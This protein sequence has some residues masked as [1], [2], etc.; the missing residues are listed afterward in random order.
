MLVTFSDI[1]KRI[2]KLGSKPSARL[3]NMRE[4]RL[5]TN[6]NTFCKENAINVIR[7]WESLDENTDTAYNKALDT[8]E[9][10][11]NNTNS[12]IIRSTCNILLEDV[13]KVRDPSQLMN[14]LKYRLARLKKK[15]T[16]SVRSAADKNTDKIQSNIT[17]L[18]TVKVSGIASPS[19]SSSASTDS[20][21]EECFNL[22]IDKCKL[23]MECDRIIKNYGTISKRF[24]LDKLVSDIRYPS[25]LYEAC[26]EIASC[27]DTYNTTFKRKYNSALE[28]TSYVFDKHFMSYPKNKIIESVT[29]YFIFYGGLKE[30]TINDVKQIKDSS[31]L[32][33]ASDFNNIDWLFDNNKDSVN[34][35]EIQFSDGYG[36]FNEKGLGNIIKNKSKE[37]IKAGKDL[38]KAAKEGNPDDHRDEE[39]KKMVSDFRASCVKN[40]DNKLNLTSL[41]SLITKIFTKTPE[42][43]VY[44]T[45]NIL[46]II[47]I[48]FIIGVGVIHPILMVCAYLV[49]GILKI[50]LSRKQLEKIIKAYK[51]EIETVNNKIEKTKDEETKK[52]LEKYVTE[53][54]VDLEKITTYEDDVYTDDEND[55][56]HEDDDSSS[57]DDFDF[58]DDDFDFDDDDFDFEELASIE[59]I[60][61]QM[62]MLY[63][64]VSEDSIDDII[65]DNIYR[66]DNDAIDAITDFS[67]TVPTILKK[68]N[69]KESLCNYRDSLRK[70]ANNINDYIRIDC[71]NENIYKINNCSTS[72]ATASTIKDAT[73]YLFCLNEIAKIKSDNYIM[74]NMNFI[75]TIKLSIDQLKR[76]AVKLSDKEKQ[77]SNSI[78]V[79]ANTAAKSMED[80][81]MTSNREAVIKGRIIPSASKCIKLALGAGAVAWALSPAIA[82]IGVLG[83]FACSKQLQH[84]ERQLVL[85]DIDIELK[86][87]ERY[88]QQAE[89][90]G[91]LKKVRQIEVMQRNLE[92]QK[93]RIKHRM[94]MQ[95][96]PKNLKK[97]G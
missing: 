79:A 69:L 24:N 97:L 76:K 39:V 74:E 83:I 34:E 21:T 28:M 31:V 10:I 53:L 88:L 43:I 29:D 20:A 91:D 13:T 15:S 2:I 58:D 30:D 81:L 82:V 60:S 35:N 33:E 68:D 92:R 64:S 72:Y 47:R 52:R 63:E 7:N 5:Y 8:F 93:Q 46:T 45:P 73:Y 70:S 3:I 19:S 48:G 84:K 18:K 59:I 6:N 32:F 95:L 51:S 86:M 36:Y 41:K 94:S 75:N 56:R 78:D 89:N 49:D 14:S 77:V 54:Q 25:D 38:N 40:K 55:A 90:E 42:Q 66:L 16:S 61:D 50:H 87:C 65:Y 1:N 71:L 27:I 9:E 85:D 17:A 67:I 62:A 57:N 4:A 23:V 22:L 37:I 26:F 44:E 80:A 96:T 12:S 11:C